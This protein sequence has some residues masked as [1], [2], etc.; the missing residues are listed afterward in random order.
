MPELEIAVL[1]PL[2]VTRVD[3]EIVVPRGRVSALLADL[4]ANAGRTLS[5]DRLL[6]DIYGV[7]LPERP[8]DAL[9]VLVTRARN[10]IG[11][12]HIVRDKAG[13]RLET[14]GLTVD[15]EVFTD[16]MSKALVLQEAGDQTEARIR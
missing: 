10:A 2:R 6:D 15:A 1:G 13:Y 12:Q 7:D 8:R 11:A 3:A 9:Y 14:D 16:Q 4:A 5:M